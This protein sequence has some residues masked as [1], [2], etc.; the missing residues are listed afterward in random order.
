[1]HVLF[2][3]VVAGYQFPCNH[4][5][6]PMEKKGEKR[7]KVGVNCHMYKVVVLTII[8][9]QHYSHSSTLDK[10]LY[11]KIGLLSPLTNYLTYLSF[12]FTLIIPKMVFQLLGGGKRGG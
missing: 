9:N 3:G 4:G 10:N 12:M 5:D 1:M 7:E 8:K 11:L 6:K 2:M